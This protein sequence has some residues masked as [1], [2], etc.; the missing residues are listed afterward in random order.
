MPPL[1]V[2]GGDGSPT[3]LAVELLRD[4]AARR[5]IRLQWVFTEEDP[6][7]ALRNGHVD[8]WPILTITP[9][10]LRALYI[11]DPLLETDHCLGLAAFYRR[12]DKCIFKGE[13]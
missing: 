4:A 5:G 10:R 7:S 11:S 1:E 6:E 9:E 2:R 3:G 8:L 13:M 12:R